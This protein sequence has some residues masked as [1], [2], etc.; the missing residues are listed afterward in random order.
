[1]KLNTQTAILDLSGKE[2]PYQDG[3]FTVGIALSNILSEAK[4]GGKMKLF[5][6]A[7]K[8]F[9]EKS[10]EID[11]ADLQIIKG[12]VEAT[13]QY[14]NIITGQLLVFLDTIKEDK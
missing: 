2:I 13:A 12:A 5:I 7:Q 8:L 4:E 9:T 3:I 6:L 10:I 14:N 11:T 1:M